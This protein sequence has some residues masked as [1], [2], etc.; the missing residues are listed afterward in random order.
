[1]KAVTEL[2]SSE[3]DAGL[4]KKI[5][6]FCVHRDVIEGLR[7]SLSKYGVVTLYGGTDPGTKMRNV[8]KF[9][10]R[11]KPRVFIGNIAAAGTNITL[12]AAHHVTFVEQDFVPGNNA[13]AAMRVHRIGQKDPVTV[14]FISLNNPMDQ[15]I[16]HI[17]KKK[18][19]ELTEIFD[20]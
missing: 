1:V 8:D 3:L 2:I 9:Q 6:L 15:K 14:R 12:T 5:V 13:Q 16:T 19:K 17:L 7:T 11:I 18:T 10:T 4:Y 20:T